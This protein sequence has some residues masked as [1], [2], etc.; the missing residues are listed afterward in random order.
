MRGGRAVILKDGG[1]FGQVIRIAEH[2]VSQAEEDD[3]RD[4]RID[5][6]HVV[7][8]RRHLRLRKALVVLKT[9]HDQK[10]EF[11]GERDLAVWNAQSRVVEVIDLSAQFDQPRFAVAQHAYGLG[12]EVQREL[13][14]VPLVGRLVVNEDVHGVARDFSA[15]DEIGEHRIRDRRYPGLVQ[16]GR[17]RRG[18]RVAV[19]PDVGTELFGQRQR[20]QSGA[21]ER[22]EKRRRIVVIGA[23]E[24]QE[25]GVVHRDL[26]AIR[27]G[28]GAGA[29][30]ADDASGQKSDE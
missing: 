15:P 1:G 26:H 18:V 24:C 6:Q 11:L 2:L 25:I 19:V 17:A 3:R 28:L 16:Q 9:R 27:V 30:D 22:D 7:D 8:Q 29:E 20:R 13:R 10:S 14:L 12:L 21:T 23:R 4:L 5:L